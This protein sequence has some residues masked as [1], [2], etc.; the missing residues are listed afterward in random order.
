VPISSTE[1]FRWCVESGDPDLS[2]LSFKV[3]DLNGADYSPVR[4]VP[5]RAAGTCVV[6]LEASAVWSTGD[7]VRL[8]GANS[9]KLS[10]SGVY[11]RN[12]TRY[13]CI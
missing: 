6:S 4:T 5:K 11:G 1:R 2:D 9:G 12:V 10:N 3:V 7:T 13:R 8:F